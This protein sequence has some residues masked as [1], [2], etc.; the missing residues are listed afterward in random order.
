MDILLQG[1]ISVAGQA[2]INGPAVFINTAQTVNLAAQAQITGL[3]YAPL[4]D[5]SLAGNAQ[6]SGAVFVKAVALTGNARFGGSATMGLSE[7]DEG[8]TGITALSGA[9]PSFA[10]RDTYAFPNPAKK[11]DVTIRAQVGLADSVDVQIYDV[12]GRLVHSGSFPTSPKVVD[13]GNGK[14]EQYSYDY[15]WSTSG[16]GSGVYTFLIT[17]RKAGQKEIRKIGRAGVL[18]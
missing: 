11:E 9:D 12:S 8:S 16:V 13:D 15:R 1:P 4:A 6:V 14:G 2:K 17:A 7:W 18:R 5:L 10:F 3:M